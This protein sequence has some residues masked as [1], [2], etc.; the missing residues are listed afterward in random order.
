MGLTEV[1]FCFIK[2]DGT[3]GVRCLDCLNR[4]GIVV[5]VTSVGWMSEK[6]LTGFCVERTSEEGC[7][8]FD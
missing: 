2:Y 3:V 6:D 1:V 8:S 5:D 4:D 7:V